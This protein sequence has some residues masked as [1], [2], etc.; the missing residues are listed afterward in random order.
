[1]HHSY[2][3]YDFVLVAA[4]LV[5]VI[6]QLLFGSILGNI[7]STLANEESGRV[8]FEQRLSAVKVRT[9]WIIQCF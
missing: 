7:A 3:D 9:V 6:G 8:T 4:S 5:M 1:M 2:N